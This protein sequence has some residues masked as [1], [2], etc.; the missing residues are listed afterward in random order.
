MTRVRGNIE[1]TE[2]KTVVT[3][4]E[5]KHMLQKA[6]QHNHTFYILR[7]KAVIGIFARTG[8]RRGEI[9]RLELT[10]FDTTQPGKLLITFTLL[11]K[12]KGSILSNR[13]TKQ[14]DPSDFLVQPILKYLEYL[15]HLEPQPKHFLPRTWHNPKMGLPFTLDTTKH[16][17]GRQVFNIIRNL[18]NAVWCHLFR[19]RVA[20]DVV[21]KDAS[22]L[23][24][25]KVM[26]RLDL[27]SHITGFN[28]LRRFATDIIEKQK[29]EKN[30]NPNPNP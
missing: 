14:L 18:S 13:T 2:R 17:S 21:K 24:A 29:E 10:D 22:I 20:S 3:D 30:E 15:Q 11:K 26:Q 19:E 1:R 6:T 25:F 5:I 23:A 4:Q 9:A 8:K 16:I 7:D 28:Y 12:R 27:E